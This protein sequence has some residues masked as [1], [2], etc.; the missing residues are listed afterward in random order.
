MSRPPLRWPELLV[1][2]DPGSRLPLYRQLYLGL[3]EAVLAG[4]LQP[5]TA[6]PASR[7]LAT[8]LGLSRNTVL[9]AIDQLLAEGYLETAPRAG[10]R[11]AAT[12]SPRETRGRR[13]PPVDRPAQGRGSP[14]LSRRGNSIAA[15]M[16]AGAVSRD[17]PRPFRPGIP[18][19]DRFPSR[20]WMRLTHRV[21]RRLPELS[22]SDP[23]GL[24]SLRAAI[25]EYLGAARGARCVAE[26]VIVV[27]G[28]QQGLD[29]AARVLLD[30]GDTVWIEE[31]GY[32]GT[33]AAL[34]AAGAHP[35][36]VPVD[37]DGLVVAGGERLAPAARMACVTPSHQF[38]L[39]ATMSAARR[40]ELLRWGVRA[41]AWLVEDDYDSEFRY[42]SRPLACLQGMDEDGRVIYVGTFSKTLFP[43]LRLGYVVV[44]PGLVDAFRAARAA[45]DRHSPAVDQAVLA[46]F[47][48]EGHFARHVRR[49]RGLYGERREALLSALSELVG[50]GMDLGSSNEAGMHLVGRLP[51]DRDDRA[52]AARAGRLGLDAPP[53]SQY[54]VTRLERGGL[55]LGYAAYTPEAIRR[56]VERLAAALS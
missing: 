26:Q 40:V 52:V 44:P 1:S 16:P 34:L 37:R 8:H 13:L 7:G 41:G 14:G 25:A 45:A 48:A 22:Y 9:L 49:M 50:D 38:P 15:A 11:V 33:R 23:A 39:G 32:P 55:L 24:P 27:S 5:G 21:W 42:A 51:P 56:G 46:G 3:R 6:I 28:S 18:A 29:L 43:A 12:F 54:A 17:P 31:P 30:P 36:P 20:H 47:I 4:R 53:L 35:V 10:T 19:L 2:L